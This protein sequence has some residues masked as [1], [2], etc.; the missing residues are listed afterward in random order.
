MKIC[1]FKAK[2][3]M[4][5]ILSMDKKSRFVKK[6]NWFASVFRDKINGKFF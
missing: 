4:P 1:L 6:S 5:R 2:Q 3:A